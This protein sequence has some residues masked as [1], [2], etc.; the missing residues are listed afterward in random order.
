MPL[1]QCPDCQAQISDAAPTCPK[2][3]RPMV[4]P[5]SVG[6]AM[7]PTALQSQPDV[8]RSIGTFFIGGGCLLFIVLAVIGTV[9]KNC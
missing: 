3:G 4:A 9:M 1:V 6:S 8:V 5:K 7:Q 2:C